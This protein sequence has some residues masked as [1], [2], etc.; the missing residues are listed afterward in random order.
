MGGSGEGP[1]F[2]ACSGKDC[3]EKFREGQCQRWE[4]GIKRLCINLLW[5]R[6]TPKISK[7]IIYSPVSKYF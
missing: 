3:W 5:R 4:T 1:V 7:S 2:E 6:I